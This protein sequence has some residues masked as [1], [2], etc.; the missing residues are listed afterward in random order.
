MGGDGKV[1]RMAGGMEGHVVN[2]TEDTV[3]GGLSLLDFI[4]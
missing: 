1:I 4:E 2:G 3:K